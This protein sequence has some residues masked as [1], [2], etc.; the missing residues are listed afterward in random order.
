MN[1]RVGIVKG[2]LVELLEKDITFRMGLE[3]MIMCGS[4]NIFV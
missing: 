3:G 1:G 4:A 2:V